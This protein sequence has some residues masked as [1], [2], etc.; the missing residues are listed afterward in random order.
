MHN[1]GFLS[2][3]MQH[4]FSMHDFSLDPPDSLD[5]EMQYLKVFG[6]SGTVVD[7]RV[8][9]S[10]AESSGVQDQAPACAQKPGAKQSSGH[11]FVKKRSLH[12]A[13][14]HGSTMYRGRQVTL[15]DLG[16]P[17]EVYST[18]HLQLARRPRMIRPTICSYQPGPRSN[19]P[20]Y[21]LKAQTG[22]AGCPLTWEG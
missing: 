13:L 4:C 7:V 19:H 1:E 2:I 20:M 8:G 5:E 11:S 12:R 10:A 6:M 21:I 22:F 17:G 9:G 14:R 18:K 3:L 16:L 15:Q